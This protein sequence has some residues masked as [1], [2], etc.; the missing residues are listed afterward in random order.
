MPIFLQN[1]QPVVELVVVIAG[2]ATFDDA[3][4]TL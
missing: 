4:K 3:G 2:V 1:N